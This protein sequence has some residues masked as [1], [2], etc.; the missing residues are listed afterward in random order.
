M[1]SYLRN[2]GDARAVGLTY[3]VG[4]WSSPYCPPHPTNHAY[5]CKNNYFSLVA[6]ILLLKKRVVFLYANKLQGL[7]ILN[8]GKT[9]VKLLTSKGAILINKR[10]KKVY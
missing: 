5:L 8:P 6:T 7:L 4:W 9:P 3:R 1:V 10:G 2:S